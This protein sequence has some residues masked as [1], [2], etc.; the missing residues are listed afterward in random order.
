[1]RDNWTE[2]FFFRFHPSIQSFIFHWIFQIF[3]FSTI[4]NSTECIVWC[5]LLLDCV[6]NVFFQS[7]LN[8]WIDLWAKRRRRRRMYKKLILIDQYWGLSILWISIEEF[9]LYT[10]RENLYRFIPIQCMSSINFHFFIFLGHLVHLRKK[11]CWPI[12]KC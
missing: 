8:K 7:F 2:I 5:L 4:I 1:M 3:C 9:F 11:E 12:Q 6:F 10:N